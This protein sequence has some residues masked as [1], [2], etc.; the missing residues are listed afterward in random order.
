M[1]SFGI[2]HGEF[3]WKNQLIWR[4]EGGCVGLLIW[5]LSWVWVDDDEDYDE[6]A[7]AAA[8]EEEEEEEE[9]D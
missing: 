7:A 1:H 3:R 2:Y 9:E 4:G 8:E 5:P 6:D